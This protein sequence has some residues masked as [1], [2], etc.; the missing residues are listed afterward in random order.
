LIY[1][2]G[3]GTRDVLVRHELDSGQETILV[4]D[5]SGTASFGTDAETAV[6]L[7]TSPERP[8]E[9][10]L[11]ERGVERQLTRL[12]DAL[13]RMF[14]P[15]G[16]VVR[17]KST[18][19]VEVEGV[20]WLPPGWSPGRRIPLLT[21]LHGG[22]TGVA[23]HAYPVPRIYPIQLF[24]DAGIGV[25]LPNFRGSSNYG[26]PFRLLNTL[27]QGA[28]DYGDVMTGI[29][30]LVERGVADPA[31][32]GVMGWSYGGYLTGAVIT[33]THRF[34]AASIGAPATD[35]IT[36][37]GQSDGP[38]EV[39]WTYFGG[40]PWDVPRNYERHSTRSRLGDIRTPTLLQVGALDINHNG[41]IY[42]ALTDRKVPVEYVVYPREGHAIREPAHVR[43]A[44]ERNYRWFVRWL[45]P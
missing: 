39:L 18:D 17:W 10:F 25:F 9:V 11:L 37:Y 34:K 2:A 5:V 24:L 4:K 8:A 7:K 44:L 22:P 38:R 30:R 42:Q 21:E 45:K 29:D 28:G 3:Q 32:L 33:Q 1:T 6:F 27:A 14:K 20:L 41:E 19:G 43:D 13:A 31:R 12:H 16:E 23:L 40:A 26:A 15:K 35:W 36:Y